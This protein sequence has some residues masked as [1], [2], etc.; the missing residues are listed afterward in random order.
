MTDQTFQI[1]TRLKHD[2]CR[3]AAL[4][5][6]IQSGAI[7]LE[8]PEPLMELLDKYQKSLEQQFDKL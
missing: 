8:N 1:A 4:W 2:I 5:R 7:Q 6:E 3:V